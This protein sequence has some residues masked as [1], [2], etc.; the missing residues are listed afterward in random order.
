MK[1]LKLL[2]IEHFCLK[3]NV[4]LLTLQMKSKTKF[5]QSYGSNQKI[6]YTFE[7]N[8]KIIKQHENEQQPTKELGCKIKE[9]L[10]VY[11]LF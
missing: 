9:T 7:E 3:K 6:V 8:L 11:N 10:K 2:K 4:L 1:K 5:S